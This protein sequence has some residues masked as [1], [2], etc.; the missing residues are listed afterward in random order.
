MPLGR[1]HGGSRGIRGRLFMARPVF[2][3]NKYFKSRDPHASIWGP[4][5]LFHLQF[6]QPDIV[7][8]LYKAPDS[9]SSPF[10]NLPSAPGPVWQEYKA[11]TRVGFFE[12]HRK[13]EFKRKVR[14]FLS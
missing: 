12:E 13:G 2:V 10:L 8:G 1:G 4:I 14:L 11:F 6:V 9:R 3:L 7:P 5:S